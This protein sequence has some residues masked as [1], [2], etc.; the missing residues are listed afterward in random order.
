MLVSLDNLI[1]V[2]ARIPYGTTAYAGPQEYYCAR[3]LQ[4]S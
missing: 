1:E 3:K 4:K 2:G